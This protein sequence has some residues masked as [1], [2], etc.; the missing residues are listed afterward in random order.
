MNRVPPGAGRGLRFHLEAGD[1]DAMDGL[2]IDRDDAN[3][4][5]VDL[6][7]LGP[8][9]PAAARIGLNETP[10]TRAMASGQFALAEELV[11]VAVDPE[12][13]NDGAHAATPMTLALRGRSASYSG[14]P[15]NLK[16]A[17]LLAEK[18]ANVNLRI[19]N[20]DL[21]TAS[22]SPLELLTTFYLSLLKIF[23]GGQETNGEERSSMAT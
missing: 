17:K 15:R 22:E 7:A 6:F 19:P 16:L 20:H 12:Y 2:L 10:L 14:Q 21:E 3:V 18:G 13:L 1:L 23:P 4:V 5:N 9:L 8:Y 11:Q